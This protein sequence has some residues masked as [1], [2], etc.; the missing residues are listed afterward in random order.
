MCTTVMTVAAVV[1]LS[2]C[3]SGGPAG[4]GA[5]EGWT[6]VKV[7]R[8]TLERPADWTEKSPTGEAWD[9]KYVGDGIE[10]QV[11]GEF[12]DD[13]TANAA[14]SRLDLP[15]TLRLEGYKGGGMQDLEVEGADSAIRSD[16]T[17]THEKETWEGTWVIAGQ[18]PHPQTAAVAINGANPDPETVRHIIESLT[19]EKKQG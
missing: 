3:S 4:G 13:P 7:G 8:L 16:F 19:F 10:L 5:A 1:G 12:S 6:E 9:T 2:A 14:L 18:W 11:S 17:F 15:A